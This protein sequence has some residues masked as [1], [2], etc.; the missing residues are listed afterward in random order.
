[1]NQNK[2]YVIVPVYNVE[3]YIER[4]VS[5]ILNQ[6]YPNFE[7]ILVDDGSADHSP[8]L[9]DRF[10]DVHPNIKTIHKPNG[11]QSEARNVGLD[12][13]RKQ[14]DI[15]CDWVTFID[16]DDYVHP[17]YLQFLYQSAVDANANI[18]CCGY[19]KTCGS[20]I[21]TDTA[22]YRYKCVTP[23]DFWCQDRV[24][25]LMICTKLYRL[26]CI[27]DVEYPIGKIREDEMITHTILFKEERIAVL[28]TPLYYYYTNPNSTMQGGW[29]PGHLYAL[30]AF[31]EQVR[32]FQENGFDK[33][34]KTSFDTLCEHYIKQ[35][36]YI[37]ELSPKYDDYLN[38]VI[39][40]RKA[41]LKAYGR[42]YGRINEFRLRYEY[43]VAEPL[44]RELENQSFPSLVK[45]KIR[46]KLRKMRKVS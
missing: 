45:R 15:Q 30:D 39:Q 23:E 18:S 13:V 33:A 19:M 27:K 40:K 5:S 32:F 7:L 25:A 28:S 16:S 14:G 10:A 41:A 3:Q 29:H 26:G 22:E 35:T 2:I 36:K 46:R 12:Y 43:T 9:C 20:D 42:K 11:G 6:T 34:E 21:P 1:M 31:D 8:E 4:C 37:K 44:R 17:Q 24:N 38:G